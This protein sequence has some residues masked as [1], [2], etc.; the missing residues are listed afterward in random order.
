[1]GRTYIRQVTQINPSD[2]YDDT[3]APGST[4]ETNPSNIEDDLNG[5]RSMLKRVL[6]YTESGNW[7][8]EVPTINTKTRGIYQIA[9][10]LDAL[11]EHKFLF[12]AQVL[13]DITVPASVVPTGSITTVAKANLSDGE[14]FVIS[15]GTNPAVT[16]YF[17]VTGTYTPGSGYD[18]TN[19]RVN[20]SGDTT[21]DDV[22]DTCIAAIDGVG[23]GLLVDASNGGAATVT[24]THDQGGSA[25]NQTVTET[26][27]DAG[28]AVSGL[29]GGA[30]DHVTLSQ[31]S[32]ETPTETA[33]VNA[34][35]A[36][37]CVVAT[38]SGDVGSHDLAEVSGVNTINPKNLVVIRDATTGDPIL[39]NQKEILG[40]LQTETGV[41]DG[42]AFNDSTAQVQISFVVENGTAD[43]LIPCDAADIG[44]KSVNYSYVRRLNLDSLPEQAF[45]TGVFTDVSASVDVTL[46]NAIDNQAG[47]ATQIQ[48]IDW[49]I[50]DTYTLDFQTSDGGV[51]LLSIKPNAAG[52][53][54]ELN[55]DD[56]DINNVNT[57]DFA[58]G[59]AFDTGGTT[60]NVGDTAGQ[61]D[62]AAGLTLASGGAGDVKLDSV[63]EI[64]FDD[65][66]RSGS[67]FSVDLKLAANSTEWDNYETAFGEVSLLNA[68]VQ[69]ST[70]ADTE[71]TVAV[72]TAATIAAN[73]NVTGA[74]GSP[75]IDA[76]LS[77][78]STYTFVT[79]V[80][81]YLNGVLMRNGADAAANHDV[82]PGDAPA[83]GDLKFEFALTGS[84]GNPDVITMIIR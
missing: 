39:S 25:G 13:T 53:E 27:S 62:S 43:D 26:V 81:I 61:I 19:I 64:L 22:R 57:A 49:R 42:T 36:N 3:I 59:A 44:G 10:H 20:V 35:T 7:Y 30:G 76:Q 67:T 23:A 33:A 45:L 40:L 80:D 15:D 74:G 38:L 4:L 54:I 82:Y 66:Y 68:I 31:A 9:T 5:L 63:N 17:D 65:G 29:T 32:S 83:N 60:I 73:T 16:F 48:N 77:D 14:T 41:T 37:G 8:D 51:D 12:R 28:F 34:G 2:T 24:L 69:A 58:Q 55:V 46:D 11:E 72:V 79:D 18:A 70:A 21:A 56:L 1:M 78:Y 84:P 6:Y 50:S 47:P 52:D 71:K 75:N